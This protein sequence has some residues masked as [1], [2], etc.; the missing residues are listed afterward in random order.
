MR[1]YITL[2]FIIFCSIYSLG[3]ENNVDKNSIKRKTPQFVGINTGFGKTLKNTN[4]LSKEYGTPVYNT[5]SL[6]YGFYPF[7]D[8]W[9]DEAFGQPYMGIGAYVAN[10]Y[11]KESNDIGQPFSIYLFQGAKIFDLFKNTSLNY[12]FNLGFS[13][14]WNPYDPFDNPH[15]DIMGSKT[16]IHFAASLYY[17]WKISER[18]D[19]DIGG[20]F[21]HFSN[22]ARHYPNYGMNMLG[23]LV[24][25]SYHF[26]REKP[27]KREPVFC[28]TPP[29]KKH[30]DHEIMFLIT[31]HNVKVDTIGTGLSS[32][33]T[34]RNFRV[35]GL[36]YSYMFDSSLRYRWGPSIEFSY[37]EGAGVTSKRE[38]N[39]L[40]YKYYDRIYLGKFG[41]RLSLGLSM[42]GELVMPYYSFFA[43]VGYDVV[44]ANNN[45]KR[46]YQI[47]GIKFNLTE[48]IF[49]TAAVRAT[50]FSRVQYFF[51]NFGYTIEGKTRK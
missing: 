12:E 31:S 35:V 49:A 15:N 20:T 26:N 40:D 9:R 23:G 19:L 43:N 4:F 6:R 33:Y 50:D 48:K 46:L 11:R 27:F 14:N 41:E 25:V 5:L 10:Y 37:D 7:F 22:G 28:E 2:L 36:S 3:V 45:F 29:I 1:K 8:C 32:P 13:F 18:F 17:K 38:Y 44:H 16:N 39:Y 21:T 24:G 30:I 47:I 51:L 34:A 42:K